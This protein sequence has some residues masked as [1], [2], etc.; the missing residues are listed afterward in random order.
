[1][2]P[3]SSKLAPRA[4]VFVTGAGLLFAVAVAVMFSFST[5]RLELPNGLFYLIL[6]PLG[7]AA[8]GFLFGAMRSQAK[9]VGQSS[10][11][12]LELSGPA[13]VFALVVAGGLLANQTTT[14][15]LTIRVHG[16]G[17]PADVIRQGK[18]TV[19]L[20]DV[21][22]DADINS[23]GEVTFPGVASS[24]EGVAIS[25]IPDVP[26]FEL[27]SAVPI[28]IPE[29]HVITLELARR[30]YSTTVRGGLRNEAGQPVR[31]ATLSFDHGAV[32]TVSDQEGNFSVAIPK[33][34]GSTVALVVT[35][36]G[37]IVYEENVTISADQPLRI[38]LR[39]TRG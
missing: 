28:T 14:F 5:G 31:G 18:L 3:R 22:R 11:G 35:A 8:A 23:R 34:P 24:L 20:G 13:V 36:S 19:D 32:T 15:P 37:R 7:L 39:G 29:N 25:V 9:Y 17:G 2:S 21:R 12:N 33:A 38:V 10:Y 6:I 30:E 27:R 26:D 4:W 1:M 16:P